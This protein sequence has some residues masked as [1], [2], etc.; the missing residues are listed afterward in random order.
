MYL[1]IHKE[2][3]TDD[4][5]NYDISVYDNA[6]LSTSQTMASPPQWKVSPSGYWA[7]V[8]VKER[9]SDAVLA[10]LT[11]TFQGMIKTF[12]TIEEAVVSAREF[13]LDFAA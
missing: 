6:K 7:Y 4:V 10:G 3:V 13:C 12:G 2:T 5:Y 9:A 8:V 1:E 11:V